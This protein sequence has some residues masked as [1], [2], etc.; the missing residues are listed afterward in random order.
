M[1]VLVRAG[2]PEGRGASLC[3]EKRPSMAQSGRRAGAGRGKGYPEKI[4]KASRKL[5]LLQKTS[6][7]LKGRC[8]FDRN[9]SI[10]FLQ[11]LHKIV[12]HTIL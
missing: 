11:G 8:F 1:T 5:L 7:L 4:R 10:S 3:K 2:F 6:V 12:F 9:F